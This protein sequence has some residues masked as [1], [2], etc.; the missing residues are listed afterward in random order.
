L[1]VVHA[2]DPGK[3]GEDYDKKKKED[4]GYF[5]PEDSA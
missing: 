1:G 2:G 3:A 4:A 5:K